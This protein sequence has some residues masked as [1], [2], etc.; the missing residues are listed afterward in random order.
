[1][2]IDVGGEGHAVLDNEVEVV[3]SGD[4]DLPV[5][6]TSAGV[7]SVLM[8]NQHMMMDHSEDILAPTSE[9]SCT[10]QRLPHVQCWTS[11]N[12]SIHLH[13][14]YCHFIF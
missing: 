7:V 5:E 3:A 14:L 11:L 4:D 12:P 1:M 13:F 9:V 10:E 2:E 8:D 6:V